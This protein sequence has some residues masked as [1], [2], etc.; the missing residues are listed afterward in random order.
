MASTPAL[1]PADEDGIRLPVQDAGHTWINPRG[2]LTPDLVRNLA[3]LI[4]G[5]AI[6][7]AVLA[8]VQASGGKAGF[9]EIGH[10][11]GPQVVASSDLY[12]ALNNMD[13]QLANAL[14]I[15]NAQGLRVTREQVLGDYEAGRRQAD[16]DLQ[17]ASALAGDDQRAATALRQALDGF[18]HYQALA[19]QAIQLDG[20]HPHPAAR[21][22]PAVL[23]L[24]RQATS[25]MKGTVLPAAEALRT[26]NADRVESAYQSR[27]RAL[28]VGAGT[29]LGVGLAVV[30]ALAVLQFSLA[31]RTRRMVAPALVVATL[32]ALG[33]TILAT[34]TFALAA[35]HL[36]VAKTDA[37]DSVL[38]LTRGRA[39][40]WDANADES[41][42]LADP[43]QADLYQ[44]AFYTK[45]NELVD[46]GSVHSG[47]YE[48][49]LGQDVS[50][51][52]GSAEQGRYIVTFGGLLGKE[53]RNITFPGE[54]A[55]AEDALERWQI[56]QGNDARLRDMVAGGQLQAAVSFDTSPG[57]NASNGSFTAFDAAMRRVI[58][59]N[60]EQFT[61]NIK[62]GGDDL[63]GWT[64]IPPVG[65]VVII[66]LVLAGVRPRLAEYR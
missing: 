66:V 28:N 49:S 47:G 5:L 42:Y 38:A 33:G 36:R 4:T 29:V 12:L 43:Q 8:S 24:Y 51:Y 32:V 53:F 31:R 10:K 46:T 27:Y 3:I 59:V 65:A 48:T 15:G 55:A 61:E 62:T 2:W 50:R 45:A 57:D 64:V 44:T 18:G 56:Y 25:E 30:V 22:S 41:R 26:A 20:Q 19:A 17:K 23:T 37:F 52:Q 54:R 6:V 58:D 1:L 39:I 16:T 9:E 11:A 63:S 60:D 34:F 7:L 14:L 35:D 13:A 21:P 40:A